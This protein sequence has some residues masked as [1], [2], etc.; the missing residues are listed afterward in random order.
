MKKLILLFTFIVMACGPESTLEK[1]Y[2]YSII[3]TSGVTVQIIPYTWDVKQVTDQVTLENNQIF[4]KKE[5]VYAPYTGGLWMPSLFIE[6]ALGRVTHVEIVFNNSKKVI[7]TSCLETFNCNIQ[8]RN[9]FNTDFND[10]LI[11]VYTIT[12]EDFQ[13]AEDCGGNCN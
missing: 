3:N 2:D 11:E 6:K 8:P 10:E 13:N 5:T 9:I 1:K 4:N 7:Y 12:A